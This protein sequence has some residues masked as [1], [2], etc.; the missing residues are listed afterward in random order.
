MGK[1]GTK[2][3]VKISSKILLSLL[4]IASPLPPSTFPGLI[5]HELFI[6]T[7]TRYMPYIIIMKNNSHSKQTQETKT[8]TAY[9]TIPGGQYSVQV[10]TVLETTK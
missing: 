4:E 3:F 10:A 8:T 5:G 2:V 6:S 1:Y 9:T 7:H